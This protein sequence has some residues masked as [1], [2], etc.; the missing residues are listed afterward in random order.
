MA[1]ESQIFLGKGVFP[2]DG[3]PVVTVLRKLWLGKALSLGTGSAESLSQFLDE[4]TVLCDCRV[5]FS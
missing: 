5:G 3:W 2:A 4:N 1:Q